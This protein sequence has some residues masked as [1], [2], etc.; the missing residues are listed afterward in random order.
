[1]ETN[2]EHSPLPWTVGEYAWNEREIHFKE[3]DSFF[4]DYHLNKVA[5][6]QNKADAAFIVK[7][8]NA[9]DTLVAF[10]N[11]FNNWAAQD[12]IELGSVMS[13]AHR[14]LCETIMKQANYALAAAGEEVAK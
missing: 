4:G 1:M 6:V 9:H 10:V 13:D 3:W 7:C 5:E 2:N 8:V 12:L 14:N 11:Q